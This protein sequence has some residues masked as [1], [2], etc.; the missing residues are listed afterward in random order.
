[1]K[2]YF[3]NAA[4]TP[5]APAVFEAMIPFLRDHFGNPNSMHAHGRESRS[6][7]ERARK[8]VAKLLGA[9]PSEIIFTSGGTESDNTAIKGA[10]KAYGLKHII[11]TAIEHHAVLHT[12]EEL[13]QE[14]LISCHFVKLKEHGAVDMDHL[15]E[16]LK[17]Y[18]TSALVTLM[19]G[20]N[21]VGNLLDIEK[22]GHLC[23][24]HGAKFHTDAVQ[25]VGHYPFNLQES[26]IDFLAA[27]AHK[28]NGPKGVGVLYIKK[29]QKIGP[30]IQG[31]GQERGMRGG[32]ENVASI[33]GLAEAL[34][35]A[36]HDMAQDRAHAEQL[37]SHMIN[38][39]QQKM[40]GVTFNGQSGALD[41]S[42]YGVLNVCLPS[43]KDA[44]MLLFS[45][46]LKGISASGGSACSAGALTGSHVLT[47]I[48]VPSDQ[49][50]IRFS[51]GKYNTI[52]EANYVIEQLMGI[53]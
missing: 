4:T 7:V 10:V 24:E 48:G 53:L 32:T 41:Q 35:L 42:L 38:A 15:Q 5:V 47:A 20:N 21:E 22:V 31:G 14:G 29:D 11:T 40:D 25:T 18:G 23:K 2:V 44:G 13:E 12:V 28:F 36:H 9:A 16:L 49:P 3:D 27:S 43:T 46:D 50:S 1:M 6:A 17:S 45:L 26:N 8:V 34:S 39:L 30:F 37:K 52:E 33:V 51:F 19:H